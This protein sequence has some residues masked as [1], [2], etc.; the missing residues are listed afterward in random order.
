[1]TWTV[2]HTRS[3]QR[4]LPRQRLSAPGRIFPGSLRCLIVDYSVAG[5]RVVLSDPAQAPTS[6]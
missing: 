4:V 5:A 1:M 3:K 2:P 6:R